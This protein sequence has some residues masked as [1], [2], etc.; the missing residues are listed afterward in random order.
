MN[1]LKQRLQKDMFFISSRFNV[2]GHMGL[3]CREV[4]KSKLGRTVIMSCLA[5]LL[6]IFGGCAGGQSLK[7]V[8]VQGIG[9]SAGPYVLTL[10][11][12]AQY[13]GLKTMAFLVPQGNGYTLTPYA[14]GYAYTTIR[15]VGGQEGLQQAIVFISKNPVYVNYEIRRILD[16]GGNTVGFEIRPLYDPTANGRSD[17]MWVEYGLSG[18]GAVNAHI[19]LYQNI[20]EEYESGGK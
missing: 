6:V 14:P 13:G 11:H 16:P 15:N 8:Q 3:P 18:G 1:L 4:M 7:A 2:S 12:E 17:V 10:Y 20:M 9:D 19:H 5:S